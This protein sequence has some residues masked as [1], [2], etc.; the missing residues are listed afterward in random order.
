MI[1][2]LLS[3]QN[4]SM[5]EFVFEALSAL[6]PSAIFPLSDELVDGLKARARVDHGRWLVDCIFCPNA[7][8]LDPEDPRTFCLSCFN[9]KGGYGWVWV[10]VPDADERAAIEKVL[11]DGRDEHLQSW[12]PGQT[13]DQLR[14][15]APVL[16]AQMSPDFALEL[17][18]A[19]GDERNR[20]QQLLEATRE[21]LEAERRG[22]LA[23]IRVIERLH[24]EANIRKQLNREL[25]DQVDAF[26]QHGHEN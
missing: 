8:M 14:E 23:L 2:T 10:E 9:A 19:A 25:Q 5:R 11:E 15:E 21:G 3:R 17:A 12:S 4:K 16:G 22:A 18:Q 24:I 26:Q 7:V 20:L 1:H 6:G 13:L